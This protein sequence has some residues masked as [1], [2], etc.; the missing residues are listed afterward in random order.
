MA[1]VLMITACVGLL[2]AG[3]RVATQQ[4]SALSL[5]DVLEPYQSGVVAIGYSPDG[6][7]LATAHSYVHSS[8]SR[9]SHHGFPPAFVKLWDVQERGDLATF[10][11]EDG[12]YQVVRF[13]PDGKNLMVQSRNKLF[14]WDIEKQTLTAEA[15]GPI[16]TI[17]PDCQL[18]A[19]FG[20]D[21]HIPV[22]N[23]SDGTEKLQ[24][25]VNPD[26]VAR[27]FSPDSA[28]LA[29]GHSPPD[30]PDHVEIWNLTSGELQSRTQVFRG[31]GS[32]CSFS[33]GG[34]LL[35]TATTSDHV[36]SVWDAES[37]RLQAQ[38][39]KH[40]DSI[41]CLTFSPDGKFIASGSEGAEGGEIR[42]WDVALG[43]Q[44]GL[45]VDDSTWG[46]TAMAFSPDG[47][48]LATG[49]G[50]GNIKVWKIAELR[51]E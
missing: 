37:G 19:G 8:D 4:H 40:S 43:R 45:V 31:F 12:F 47:T 2:A 26:A 18:V 21:Y 49:D 51:S 6:K 29:V 39:R 24:L 33:P 3:C 16:V 48:R 44:Q 35:A 25:T 20:E 23:V 10:R 13:A 17:S 32:C 41:W 42:L 38:L 27:A 14:R 9:V 5:E 50:D 36:V 15:V 22:I 1:R 46:I 30:G 28:L 7:L 34:K 11:V